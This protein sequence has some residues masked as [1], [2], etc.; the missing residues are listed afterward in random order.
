MVNSVHKAVGILSLLSRHDGLG[1]T[2]ISR[3]LE[4]PKSSVHS[5]LETLESEQLVERAAESRKFHLGVRLIELGNQAQAELDIVKVA[6]PFLK[7]LNQETDETVHLT[8]LDNDEVLYVDCLESKKRLR[9]YSVIGIR[10][11][12]YCTSV[13]KAMLAFQPEEEIERIIHAVPLIRMTEQTITNPDALR[14][15]LAAIRERGYAV[16]NMEHEEHLRC[17]GA[18]IFDAAGHAFA[19]VSISGPDQR[20]TLERIPEIAELVTATAAEISSRFGYRQ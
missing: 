8:L 18:P 9:T 5:I 3:Q 19:S 16:D 6:S 12:L 20:N 13:G 15:E 2:E 17:V 11:P 4:I 1:V 7:Q 10:A 14:E